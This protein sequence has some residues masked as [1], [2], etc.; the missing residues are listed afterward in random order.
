MSFLACEQTRKKSP[1][2]L[3]DVSPGGMRGAAGG[4]GGMHIF[5]KSL[6]AIEYMPRIYAKNIFKEFMQE[7]LLTFSTPAGCGGFKRSAHS[8]VPT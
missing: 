7:Y 5:C 4:F 3:R 6:H 8:D 1:K 2:K